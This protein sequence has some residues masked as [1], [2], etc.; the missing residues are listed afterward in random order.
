D[1][2][3]IRLLQTSFGERRHVANAA[4]LNPNDLVVS[5]NTANPAFS[6]SAGMELET[7]HG[8]GPSDASSHYGSQRSQLCDACLLRWLPKCRKASGAAYARSNGCRTACALFATLAT[9]QRRRGRRACRFELCR[10][11]RLPVMFVCEITATQYLR[12][13]LINI[14][15]MRFGAPAFGIPT[16]RVDGNDVFALY[17]VTQQGRQLCLTE[18]RPTLIEMNDFIDWGITARRMTAR[19]IGDSVDELSFWDREDNPIIRM[20]KFLTKRGWWSDE[21]ETATKQAI[22]KRVLQKFAQAER[23]D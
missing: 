1:R 16:V 13:R 15:A 20:R 9:A 4:A 6:C 11:A 19:L 23:S 7:L 5:A 17:E 10:H 22:R 3:R 12:L 2:R 14:A 21:Q 8:P 18:M